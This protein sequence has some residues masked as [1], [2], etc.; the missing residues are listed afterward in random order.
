MLSL[1]DRPVLVVGG[2]AVALRKVEGLIE[3]GARV[4]VVAPQ[5]VPAIDELA[6]RSLLKV[7]RRPYAHGDVAG[8][9]L[10]FAATDDRG[11]NGRV[12]D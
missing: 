9:A 8:F 1:R 10:V 11:T 5:V 2:G 4:T 12:F 3:A 7:E 6:R